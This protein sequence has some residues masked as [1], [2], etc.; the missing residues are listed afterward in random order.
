M[1]ESL[2]SH[3]SKSPQSV[4][5][6]SGH[7]LPSRPFVWQPSRALKSPASEPNVARMQQLDTGVLQTLNIPAKPAVKVT[8]NTDRAAATSRPVMRPVEIAESQPH[9]S[10]AAQFAPEEQLAT[11]IVQR[12]KSAY[13][14]RC[15]FCTGTTTQIQKTPARSLS[16][17]NGVLTQTSVVQKQDLHQGATV[18]DASGQQ[19]ITSA[20][21]PQ[22]TTSSSGAVTVRTW[23]GHIPGGVGP[24]SLAQ[25]RARDRT[26]RALRR[27]IYRALD[28]NLSWIRPMARQYTTQRVSPTD[29]QGAGNAAADVVR[30]HVGG[31]IQNSVGGPARAR[32][33]FTAGAN[34]LDAYDPADRATAGEP[35][36]AEAVIWWALAN[37]PTASVRRAFAFNPDQEEDWLE[38]VAIP[39]IVGSRRA[40]FELWDRF[41]FAMVG[42]L[43]NRTLATTMPPDGFSQ[44]APGSGGLAPAQ[45]AARWASFA[46]L[47][48]E[49]FHLV[50]HPA[51]IEARL[52]SDLGS[53]LNE[54]VT[55][56]LTEDTYNSMIAS[57]RRDAAIIGRVEGAPPPSG[58]VVPA[59]FLPARYQIAYPDEVA[60]V[61]SALGTVSLDGFKAAYLMGHV[62]YEGLEPSGNERTPVAAGTGQGLDIPSSVTTLTAL[63]RGSGNTEAA[64]RAA[65]PGITAWTPLPRR[66]NV[67]G[68]REHIVVATP[69][70]RVESLPQIARQHDVTVADLNAHNRH[71][72]GWPTLTAGMKVLIPPRGFRP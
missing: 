34:L 59:R 54:G 39:A 10:L 47:M 41:G 71:H 23:D 40:D 2:R 66:L 21:N 1:S 53:A 55:D 62:E 30:R 50:E 43:G 36:S 42:R 8:E 45:R 64:I 13:G 24:P 22:A 35:I 26:L 46:E 9:S 5:V 28:Q 48:H 69:R 65:N 14:C 20:M 33:G 16:T 67:P 31:Y 18:P 27:G 70:G 44:T 17:A 12:Q 25:Q 56:I 15:P 11:Q 19:A 6:N 72:A 38:T 29:L 7:Q 60:D 32:H 4:P 57:V 37:S 51:H 63:A 61:R 3:A 52:N 58:T 49:F 68:W